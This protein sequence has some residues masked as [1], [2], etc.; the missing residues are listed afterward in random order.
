MVGVESGVELTDSLCEALGLRGNGVALSE[1]RRDK[2]KMIETI[3]AAGLRA[4]RQF[5]TK[6]LGALLDW[7]HQQ[8]GRIV[9]K[10]LRSAGTDGVTFCDTAADVE[11]GFHRIMD[12]VS[13]LELFNDS[14]L[15]QEYLD[16]P[17]Y[18]INSVSLDGLHHVCDLW[19]A[20]HLQANGIP[21]LLDSAYLL[22]RQ[23]D[24]QDLLVEYG[25]RALD[26]LGITNGPAH[27]ELRMT[28]DGPCLIEVGARMVGGDLPQLVRDAGGE[29]QIEWTLDAYLDPE[30]F[31][32]RA[33]QTYEIP[34]SIINT[35]IISEHQGT[36]VDYRGLDEIRALPSFH[37]MHLGV[38]PGGSL[39]RSMN[40]FTYPAIIC[41]MHADPATARADYL[42][43]R[44]MNR[45]GLYDV[46]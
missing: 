15:A 27:M 16:G 21:Q 33:G 23:G 43:L 18:Y 25:A 28:K 20:T 37:Q 46:A 6:D 9:I 32:R 14:V 29:S 7:F 44:A 3:R 2:F 34:K 13:M 41:L 45:E 38:K 8:E 31:R 19:R 24:T 39:V 10:P 5:Q 22:P 11:R 40:L 17:E 30:R 1:A 12:T 36:L 35:C 42:R 26:A 4:A